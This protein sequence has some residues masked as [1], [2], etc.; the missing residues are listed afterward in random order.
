MCGLSRCSSIRR[1][2]W[3]SAPWLAQ[4]APKLAREHEHAVT[5]FQGTE[6]LLKRI[7]ALLAFDVADRLGAI[8]CPTLVMAARDDM[9]VPWT[10]SETLAA[11]IPRARLSIVAEGGHGFTVTEA[12]AFNAALCGFLSEQDA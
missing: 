10:A 2:G 3:Y 4:N 5:N 12:D 9:L 11:G 1:P 7:A 6:T 8:G